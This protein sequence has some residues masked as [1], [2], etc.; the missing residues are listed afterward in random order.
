[1]DS[2]LRE[3]RKT[4]SDLH[5]DKMVESGEIPAQFADYVKDDRFPK[6]LNVN[7]KWRC[8]GSKARGYAKTTPPAKRAPNRFIK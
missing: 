6:D 5:I 7:P 2:K 3:V 8:K 1:M 4:A